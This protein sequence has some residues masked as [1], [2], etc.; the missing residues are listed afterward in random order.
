VSDIVAVYRVL[1]GVDGSRLNHTLRLL[2]DEKLAEEFVAME[3]DFMN[4][5]STLHVVE[6]VN[7]QPRG[8]APL[9]RLLAELGI[10]NIGTRT[11]KIPVHDSNLVV[12]RAQ[13]TLQ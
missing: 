9:P 4:H 2:S 5:V 10:A 3:K 7:G 1:V 11:V 8:V 13:V 12:P 6:L